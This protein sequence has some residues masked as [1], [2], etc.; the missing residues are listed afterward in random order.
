MPPLAYPTPEPTDSPS[1]RD[2][3]L[4]RRSVDHHC[5]TAPQIRAPKRQKVSV[6]P[7]TLCFPPSHYTGNSLPR[8]VS[9]R[10]AINALAITWN[11][12]DRSQHEYNIWELNDY[13][14]Y[15]NGRS[16]RHKFELCPLQLLK[17]EDGVNELLFDG[18]LSIDGEE[19]VVR[20]IPFDCLALE[21]YGNESDEVSA[22][23]QTTLGRKATVWYRLRSP[24]SQHARYH[25]TFLWVAQFTKYVVDFLQDSER[26]VT[27]SIF[28]RTS[29]TY[30]QEQ[31]GSSF[32]IRD[33][34]EQHESHDIGQAFCAN[35][36]F[37]IKECYSVN[38]EL[39]EEPIFGETDVKKLKAIKMEKTAYKKTVVTP[40]VFDLF[41][42]MPFHG[43]MQVLSEVSVAT[44]RKQESR[45]I[46]LG[47]TPLICRPT[48]AP[49]LQTQEKI[50]RRGD[51][52]SIAADTQ[53]QWRNSIGGVWYAFVQEVQSSLGSE[54]TY[55][56]ENTRSVEG[57]DRVH[58]Y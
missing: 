58:H 33:W 26:P 5:T 47:L 57:W 18:T 10:E 25:E 48:P 19:Q 32:A 11:S 16:Y 42:K 20:G 29:Y 12:K 31:Y 9:E 38:D 36:G 53:N 13:S 24:V 4:K 46:E 28:R 52:V 54:G 17:N 49:V 14:I 30:L 37:I 23:I 21:G 8:A 56:V 43:Q 7:V 45:R 51:V 41:H 27:F 22:C 50:V 44:L 40:F 1:S 55:S 3:S 35:L 39:L 6:Q 34:I 15:R 2:E